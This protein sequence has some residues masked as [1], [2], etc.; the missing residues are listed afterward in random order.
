MSLSE[1]SARSRD[2]LEAQIVARAWSDEAFRARLQS[3]PRAA[4]AEVTGIV[5]P[6]SIEIGVV[7]ETA[8][9]AYLVIPLNRVAIAE[10]QLDAVSGGAE[11]C[12]YGS[13]GAY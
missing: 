2:E 11:A 3:D 4:V 13:S 7:E 12:S 10:D 9:K 6:Q 1:P 5:V 8:E